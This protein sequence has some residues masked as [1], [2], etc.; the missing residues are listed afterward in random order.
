M[1]EEGYITGIIITVAC[2]L[3]PMLT[4]INEHRGIP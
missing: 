2:E 1:P 3:E 4:V